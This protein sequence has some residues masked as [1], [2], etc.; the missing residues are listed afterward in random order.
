MLNWGRTSTLSAI[1]KNP[2]YFLFFMIFLIN[3]FDT[4]NVTKSRVYPCLVSYS[5]NNH[6][7]R[8]SDKEKALSLIRKDADMESKGKSRMITEIN[9]ESDIYLDEHEHILSKLLRVAWSRQRLKTT[10]VPQS[11]DHNGSLQVSCRS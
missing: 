8:V 7:Y 9:I 5:V 3:V 6:M 10:R 2:N 11:L 1:L 4:T